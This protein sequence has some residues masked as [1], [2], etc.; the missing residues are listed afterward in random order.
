MTKTTDP[1]I[2]IIHG[3]CLS[4]A[5]WSVAYT[6]VERASRRITV[7]GSCCDTARPG[8]THPGWSGRLPQ[9]PPRI[10][11]IATDGLRGWPLRHS[12]S[13][14]CTLPFLGP[15]FVS[16][17][18]ESGTA[19][20]IRRHSHAS[21]LCSPRLSVCFYEDTTSAIRLLLRGH[22]ISDKF[23][24]PVATGNVKLHKV[25]LYNA[26]SAASLPRGPPMLQHCSF[27]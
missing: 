19:G 3:I 27:F 24:S 14:D 5:H 25:P 11:L 16:G 1:C 17:A 15:D 21:W 6:P 10:T 13:E 20:I 9:S 12:I 22:D 7:R 26:L 4:A 8:A 2:I 23:S 18:I